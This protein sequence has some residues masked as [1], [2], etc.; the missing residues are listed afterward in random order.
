MTECLIL[1]HPDLENSG[2]EFTV[3]VLGIFEGNTG[4]SEDA[5]LKCGIIL[6]NLNQALN[7]PCKNQPSTITH[8]S[9]LF[10]H[11]L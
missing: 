4:Y 2:L 1:S 10:L 11:Y 3:S 7:N 5:I 9:L 8:F 6:T